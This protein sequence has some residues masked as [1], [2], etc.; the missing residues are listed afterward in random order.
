[1]CSFRLLEKLSQINAVEVC[2]L[3]PAGKY[4]L[5]HRQ[6]R[7]KPLSKMDGCLQRG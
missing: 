7:D 3:T 6:R 5:R 1:M 2:R 4:Q